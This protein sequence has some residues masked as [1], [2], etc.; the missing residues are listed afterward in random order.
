MFAVLSGLRFCS[1]PECA[2]DSAL[3]SREHVELARESRILSLRS[4]NAGVAELAD[5]LDSKSTAMLGSD[6]TIAVLLPKFDGT[7]RFTGSLRNCF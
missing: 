7:A 3:Y 1:Q 2:E 6:A 4:R 5:A